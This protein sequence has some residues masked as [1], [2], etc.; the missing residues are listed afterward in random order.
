MRKQTNLAEVKL[1]ALALLSTEI[2][3]TPYSP[4]IVKHPFTD[5]GVSAIPDGKGGVEMIDLTED[6]A[7]LRWRQ[8]M[9]RQI[10]K[11]DSAYAIYMMVTKPYALTFLKFAQPSLSRE[12]MSQI[13][14]SAWTRSEAPHQ[15][16]NVTVNQLLRMFKQAD[17]TCLMEQDEYIQFKTLDDTVTVYR[18][19]TPH[20][21]K[22]VKALSWSLNQETAEWF[23]HRFGENGTVYEAQIDKKAYIRI[24][25]RKERIRGDRRSFLSDKHYGG[26][27]SVLRF[28]IITRITEVTKMTIY[29]EEMQRKAQHYGCMMHA[30]I[31]EAMNI[32]TDITP[33]DEDTEDLVLDTPEPESEEIERT[34]Q[35]SESAAPMSD[36]ERISAMWRYYRQ[37]KEMLDRESE[38]YDPDTAVDLLIDSAKLGCDVAKYRLSS[39]RTSRRR[40]Y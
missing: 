11:A 16:V 30:V 35:E 29:Q 23:A 3:E 18:G 9:A 40:C 33:I 36:R 13:L 28:F 6:D 10:D 17:P 25:Q 27:G 39:V 1:T 7:Q 4:M 24:F 26:T 14:A 38:D 15:D 8:S 19:V 31:Q 12:D 2:N 37:A 32:L 21:A 5:T 22:S 34:E 20:N